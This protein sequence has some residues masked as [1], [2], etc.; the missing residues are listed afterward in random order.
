VELAANLTACHCNAAAVSVEETL[1]QGSDVYVCVFSDPD[2]DVLISAV[3]E[4]EFVQES[5]RILAIDNSTADKLTL[6]VSVGE[7]AIIH[8]QMRSDFFVAST[9][10]PVVVTGSVSLTF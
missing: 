6:V 8:T 9:L 10:G 5:L 2:T 7:I 3:E 4:L 1:T